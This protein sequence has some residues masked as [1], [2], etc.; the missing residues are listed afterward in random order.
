M[1]CFPVILSSPSGGGKTS[2]ARKLLQLRSDVAQSISATTRAPRAGE[3]DGES[4]RFLSQA[5]FDAAVSRGEFA[6]Y[7][8]VHGNMYGTFRA[9]VRRILDSRR[10]VLMVIDVQ[11]ARQFAAAFPD[12]VRVFVLPPSGEVLVARLRARATESPAALARRLRDARAELSAVAEFDYVVVNSVLDRAVAEVSAVIDAESTRRFRVA[13]LQETVAAMTAAL[14]RE[15]SN[16]NR[17]DDA[18]TYA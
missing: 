6:E 18:R 14:D 5:E 9:E 12:C 10:N 3:V 16:F 17:E 15:I 2:I 11:G 4:Y 1:T 7:A 13:N 8:S